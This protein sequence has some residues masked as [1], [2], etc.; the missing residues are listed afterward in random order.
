M[1]LYLWKER[2]KK[3]NETKRKNIKNKRKCKY[4]GDKAGTVGKCS[5]DRH[6]KATTEQARAMPEKRDP[7]AGS[8]NISTRT[9]G[10]ERDAKERG[11]G[12]GGGKWREG[13]SDGGE[14]SLTCDGLLVRQNFEVARVASAH[15]HN[16]RKEA[17]YGRGNVAGINVVV[18]IKTCLSPHNLITASIILH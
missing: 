2:T 10:R 7:N 14:R 8:S 9:A 18:V 5:A 4:I 3:R 6:R 12:K 16:E 11:E 13:K 1:C 17:F 15:P